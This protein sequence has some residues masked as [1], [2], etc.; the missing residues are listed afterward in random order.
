MA[1]PGGNGGKP[2]T[3]VMVAM[4]AHDGNGG[5]GGTDD[6]GGTDPVDA[7]AKDVDAH[8]VKPDDLTKR[9][10]WIVWVYYKNGIPAKA[11]ANP[12]FENSGFVITVQDKNGK[13]ITDRVTNSA[14]TGG[15]DGDALQFF[16]DTSDIAINGDR[17]TVTVEG[18]GTFT[19]RHLRHHQLPPKR[20]LWKVVI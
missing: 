4:A 8:R 11:A 10:G 12:N 6:N 3:M 18:L 14:Q 2:K 5:N 9:I 16:V 19:F 1:N 17:I 20:I 7:D 15:D 13:D